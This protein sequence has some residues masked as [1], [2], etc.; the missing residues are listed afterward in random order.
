MTEKEIISWMRDKVKKD[1]F[2]DAASLARSFLSTHN[3][4]DSLNPDFSRTMD[5]GFKVAKE[6]HKP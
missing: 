4:N 3:I 1:G 6:V 2:T 5:A